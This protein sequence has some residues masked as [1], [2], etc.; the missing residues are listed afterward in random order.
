MWRYRERL[1]VS[2]DS[3]VDQ[4]AMT[5]LLSQF[6]R[7]GHDL[8]IRGLVSS[9]SGNMSIR[10]GER[11]VITRRGSM[12]AHLSERDLVETRVDRNDRATPL[13]STELVVHRAIYRQTPA[14]AVI[15]AH[16]PHAVALSLLEREITPVDK[17]GSFHLSKVRVL[18]WDR[19]LKPNQL[20]EEVASVLKEHQIILVHGHGSFAATQLLEEAYH[21][22]SALE[23]SCRIIYLL[24]TLNPQKERLL[25]RLG[26]NLK[27][28]ILNNFN[29][30]TG[31]MD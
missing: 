24:R 16:P 2:S 11:M 5:S 8:F 22:T 31:V 23:E 7:I 30:V 6:Q 27:A 21:L 20:A 14:L 13:A 10:I 1:S 26:Q 18:G 4:A 12:L 17:E 15:H 25:P 3:W 28:T 29:Q 9:H 19:R